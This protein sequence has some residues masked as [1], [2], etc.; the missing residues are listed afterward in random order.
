MACLLYSCKTNEEVLFEIEVY[1][2]FAIHQFLFTIINTE[3]LDLYE[4]ILHDMLENKVISKR[5]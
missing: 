4:G 2:C 5:K 1:D 3:D